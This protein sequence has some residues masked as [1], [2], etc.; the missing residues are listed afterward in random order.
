MKCVNHPEVDAL[1]KCIACGSA[2]CN[3]C[4]ITANNEDYCKRCISGKVE[5]ASK[6]ERSPI[7]A[8]ILSFVIAGLGQIYNGQVGKGVLILLTSWLIIPWIYGIVDAYLI[9]KKINE[10][11]IQAK[12]ATGC[13][14]AVIIAAACMFFVVPIMGLLAAIAIPN[15]IVARENAMANACVANMKSIEATKQLWARDTGANEFAEP[16]ISDLT[17]KY[18]VSEPVCVKGGEY[19]IGSLNVPATC[20]I[21]DNGTQRPEDDHIVTK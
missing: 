9:A 5:G 16:D 17:P 7:L 20:S 8:S 21:G 4:R 15:F 13:F 19:S 18:L 2:I 10:G 6:Q 3:D 11:K 14:I 1:S 12:Q